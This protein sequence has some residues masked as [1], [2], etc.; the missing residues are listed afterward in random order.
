M[1]TAVIN[2]QVQDEIARLSQSQNV[3]AN[4]LEQFANFVIQKNYN[5][6]NKRSTQELSIG[7][8]KQAV[9]HYF[10]VKNTQEL[11]K[12]GL[13]KMSTDGM[14]ALD[15]RL[16]STWKMLYR[17]FVGVLPNEKNQEGYGCINGINIFN[18]FKPWKVFGLNPKIAT[19]EDIKKAYYNLAKIYHPDNPTTG[20][21]KIFEQIDIMYQSIIEVF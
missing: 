12:S 19:K 3:D 21:R 2:Q 20:D 14:D 5:L 4:V 13:F 7:A 10:Q 8:V 17:K 18:Y 15:F 16:A 6:K 1:A 11:K 9:Y